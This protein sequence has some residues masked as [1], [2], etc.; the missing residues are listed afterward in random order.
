VRVWRR[1]V[2]VIFQDFLH[3]ELS[4]AD[5][6]SFGAVHAPRDPDAIRRA[7]ERAGILDAFEDLPLGLDTPLGR[8]YEGGVDLSGGQWQRLAIARSLY[9]LGA[10]ARVLVLDEPTAA[11]DVRAESAFFD[12]FVDLTRGVTSLLISHRF[13]SVRRADGIVVLDGGRVVEQ[14]SH[15][16]L[17]EVDGTYARLFRLQA[18]RF[19]SGLDAEGDLLEQMEDET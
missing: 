8:M 14:G 18:E 15:A 3:Y 7:A 1:Q 12:S 13:S 9:A 16:E 19:A 5:N 11:L 17:M 4:A 6:I 2:S 10:G